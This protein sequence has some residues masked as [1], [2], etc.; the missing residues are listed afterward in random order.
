MPHTGI[1]WTDLHVNIVHESSH[2]FGNEGVEKAATEDLSQRI[3]KLITQR[4]LPRHPTHLME[5]LYLQRVKTYLNSGRSPIPCVS[6]EGNAFIDPTGTVYPCHIW[7]NP[8]GSLA[9]HGFSIPALWSTEIRSRVRKQ[10][11]REQ[12]PGCWTPCEAYPS[13][14]G[15]LPSTLLNS[16]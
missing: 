11:Q 16:N 2:F 12:C 5:R 10:V 8:I 7:D 1:K 6:L 3:E 9:D 15:G 13:I 14:L 4:G